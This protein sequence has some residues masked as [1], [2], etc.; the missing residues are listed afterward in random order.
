[1]YTKQLIQCDFEMKISITYLFICMVAD[2]ICSLLADFTIWKYSVALGKL[3][4]YKN[5]HT[6]H[7]KHAL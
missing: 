1:M 7:T 4:I 2:D 3:P 5:K 6:N